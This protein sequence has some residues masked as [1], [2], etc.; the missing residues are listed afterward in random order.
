MTTMDT[1]Q[2]RTSPTAD[3]I[4]W[5]ILTSTSWLWRAKGPLLSRVAG[6]W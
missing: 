2:D 6:V 4:E 1:Q 5:L 3:D